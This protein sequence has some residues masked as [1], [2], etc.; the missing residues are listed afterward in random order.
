MCFR[1]PNDPTLYAD[2]GVVVGRVTPAV[3][4]VYYEQ[5]RYMQ[6]GI[7]FLRQPV[8]PGRLSRSLHQGHKLPA[9]DPAEPQGLTGPTGCPGAPTHQ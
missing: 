7:V 1:N 3:P 9:L 6:V 2:W 8:C 4:L 5:G